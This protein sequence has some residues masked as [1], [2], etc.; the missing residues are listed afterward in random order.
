MN[1]RTICALC[2]KEALFIPCGARLILEEDLVNKIVTCKHFG[3]HSCPRYVDGRKEG[4]EK[5]AQEFPRVTRESL[6][7]QQVQNSLEIGGFSKA[8][9]TAKQFTDTTYI[10]N[11]RRKFKNIR[12]PDGHSFKAVQ[13]LQKSFE[14][15]A[16]FLIFDYNDGSEGSPAF[17]LKSSKRKVEVLNNLNMDGNH[18][19]AGETVHL[20]VLHSR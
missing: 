1:D 2:G 19:L 7:R 20:D 6:I 8:I 13:I 17:V 9:D 10:D 5:L 16:K 14:K 12:R 3:I 4:V 18:H 11:V 15:E